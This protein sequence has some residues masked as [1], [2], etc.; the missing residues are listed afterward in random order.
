MDAYSNVSITDASFPALVSTAITI[1]YLLIRLIQLIINAATREAETGQDKTATHLSQSK[2][3]PAAGTES[4]LEVHERIQEGIYTTPHDGRELQR[5]SE[6]TSVLRKRWPDLCLPTSRDTSTDTTESV[7]CGNVERLQSQGSK[8]TQRRNE[9]GPEDAY[10]VSARISTESGN[11]TNASYVQ[12]RRHD[13]ISST[14]DWGSDEICDDGI[15]L[16][17][18]TS[19]AQH[20]S[21]SEPEINEIAVQTDTCETI[22][23]TRDTLIAYT[24]AV[25]QNT[26]TL[27]FEQMQVALQTAHNQASI[28]TPQTAENL[29]MA[30]FNLPLLTDN[31]PTIQTTHATEPEAAAP[32]PSTSHSEQE[33]TVRKTPYKHECSTYTPKSRVQPTRAVSPTRRDGHGPVCG[34]PAGYESD[35]TWDGTSNL[36]D[37]E[38]TRN[39]NLSTFVTFRHWPPRPYRGCGQ[40]HGQTNNIVVRGGNAA[41][42]RPWDTQPYGR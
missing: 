34:I 29:M 11:Q 41:Y 1:G 2:C 21:T 37:Q 25:V 30:H 12:S 9:S 17:P 22:Y 7:L 3:C 39:N 15:T 23:I 10:L 33:E 18:Q 42:L 5:H 31:Y 4:R 36:G 38:S 16:H 20:T 8:H 6:G 32:Q 14:N 35:D 19:E 24:I 26:Q 40:S 27:K 13:A 28:E